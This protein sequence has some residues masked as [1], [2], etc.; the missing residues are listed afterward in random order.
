MSQ[1]KFGRL[2]FNDKAFH[3]LLTDSN[4]RRLVDR[5]AEEL[6]RAAGEGF[7]AHEAPSTTRARSTVYADDIESQIRDNRNSILLR[8]VGQV[9]R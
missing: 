1:I 3:E 9:K 8:S 7:T 5:K 4:A 2:R 6:A